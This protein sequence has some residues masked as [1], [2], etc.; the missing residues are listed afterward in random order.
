[1]RRMPTSCHGFSGQESWCSWWGKRKNHFFAKEPGRSIP[2]RRI[3]G[4]PS[5][6]TG[7]QDDSSKRRKVH[8]KEAH[9]KIKRKQVAHFLLRFPQLSTIPPLSKDGDQFTH[10]LQH[11]CDI[12]CS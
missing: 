4:G 6:K 10:L 11:R 5:P 12:L 9:L 1:M 7:A 2:V 3:A 8:G